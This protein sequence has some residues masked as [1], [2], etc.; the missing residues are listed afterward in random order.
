[1]GVAGARGHPRSAASACACG[2]FG[3]DCPT[4]TTP[5][6]PTTSCRTRWRCS[7]AQPQSALLRQPAGVHL[8]A[9]FP[10]R[11]RLRRRGRGRA[12]LRTSPQRGV[13]ARPRRR[14]RARRRRGLAAV[15]DG[16]AAVRPRR[17]AAGGG[18]RG[19]RVPARLLRASRA[20]RRAD[21]R[22]ADAFAAGHGGGAAQRPCARLPARRNR[23]GPCVRHQVHGRRGARAA[24]GGG[25][26]ALP[27]R[28]RRAPAG[29]RSAGS[30]SR[31]PRRSRRS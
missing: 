20:Q 25:D 13:H 30:R 22:A 17:G 31:H 19:G 2:A 27:G 12:R 28:A 1:M 6:R 14:G 26:P 15:C 5:T 7:A 23:A 18:D 24:R 4:P 8:C 16:R 21:A 10:A 9:A 3:R 29:A 11:A